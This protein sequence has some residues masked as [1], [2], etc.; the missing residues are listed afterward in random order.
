MNVIK[1][2]ISRHFSCLVLPSCKR[3]ASLFVFLISS[4]NFLFGQEQLFT[5]RDTVKFSN[6]TGGKLDSVDMSYASQLSTFPGGGFNF[7]NNTITPLFLKQH[8]GLQNF[9]FFPELS[10]MKFS[11][12][13]HIG[14]SYSFGA[15]GT[16]FL[17]YDYQQAFSRKTLINIEGQ[18]ISSAGFLRNSNFNDNLVSLQLRHYDRVYSMILEGSY[19]TKKISLS[20]GVT[21][22]SNL[23]IQ[24]LDFLPVTKSDALDSIKL[25]TAKLS[26]YFNFLADSS[27]AI[28]LVIKHQYQMEAR[29]YLE[30]EYIPTPLW[31]IDSMETRDQY[32][33]ASIRNS[34]GFY[35]KAKRIYIDAL[36][37][38]RYWDFQNL[39]VHHDTNELNFT[40]KLRFDHKSFLLN[41]DL[42]LNIIG[43]GGEWSNKSCIRTNYRKIKI[44]GSLEMEQ[45]LPEPFQRFYFSN[46]HQYSLNKYE[47]QSRLF[48]RITASYDLS[49]KTFIQVNFSNA[50]LHNNY[51]F[52]DSTWRNDTLTTLSINSLSISGSTSF[53]FIY[54][55]P[56]ITFNLPTANFNYL[57]STTINARLFIKKK[58]F[59]AQKMEGIAG[60][61]VSWISSYNLLNYNTPMDVFIFNSTP[62]QFKAMWN[63][64]AFFGFAID[65]FR[66]YARMENIG[67]FWNDKH[68][69]VLTGYPI[70][71]NFLRLGI[72]WDFFN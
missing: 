7:E 48:S 51:F 34:A 63:M 60:V 43:A 17:H 26:N 1:S 62:Q 36:V 29:V 66:F 41:N 53:K 50:I 32:R 52:I 11:A 28:G 69:Q 8:V 19:A 12:V 64:S 42:N 56:K 71:K 38:H 6:R 15:K 5:E 47:L 59:K 9:R 16:Q 55:L 40:S 37:Q 21:D 2:N 27:N 31:N 24:G 46:Y 45:K 30:N 54:L 67:Y 14:F 4:C 3:Y 35:S 13:P 49:S 20:G 10:P 61:D 58:M 57:P 68:N 25:A 70:Q 44:L 72:T 23:D 22:D 33:L 39:A 18:R 65:E